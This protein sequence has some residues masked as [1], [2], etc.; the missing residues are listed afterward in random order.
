[1]TVRELPKLPIGI[2]TFEKLRRGDYLYVDKTRYLVNLI[3]SG[4]V[5][6]MSRPRRFGKSLTISTFDALFSGKKELFRGL[7]AEE[8]MNR[9]D[10]K[11]HP[12]VRL[13]MSD[14]TTDMGSDVLRASMLRNVKKNAERLGVT[15]EYSTPGDAFS[16]LLEKAAGQH[17]SQVA[18][19]IDEYDSPILQN[20]Y[21]SSKI[22]EIRGILKNFYMRIKSADEY[23][24]FVFLTGISKFSKMGV[25]SALNNLKDISDKDGY[26]TMLGY[27]KDEMLSN[28]SA[29]I[30]ETADKRKESREEVIMQ[31]RDY[32]DGF[33]F[34]GATR[35]YNP[36]STLNFFDDA[37]F[38]NYWFESATPSY[39][40]D[41]IKRHDLETEAFRGCEVPANFTSITEIERASPESFLFQSGYLSVRKK[42]GKKLI[43][44]YPNMEV[45]S[46]VTQLFLYGKFHL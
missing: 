11:T 31:I 12:V 39:L 8:F 34:D 32:Y 16:C 20:I 13:D 30:D 25:F 2:Q 36:F 10:Y 7:F 9:P 38:K 37:T 44:D 21:D 17:G 41:Y 3:D 14:L 4:T 46:S 23:L 43:L 1:M 45:L 15:V 28:F 35:L 22:D 18:L 19:L 33:S 26:A 40:V 5:Y 29:Y 6:F 27:T 42:D 24:R